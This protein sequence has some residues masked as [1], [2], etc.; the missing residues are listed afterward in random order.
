M[1]PRSKAGLSGWRAAGGE[2]FRDVNVPSKAFGEL[3]EAA[4][5]YAVDLG[6]TSST[7]LINRGR[8]SSCSTRG[9]RRNTRR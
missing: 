2:L 6:A 8:T 5:A 4:P 7:S 3:V 1:S 9:A